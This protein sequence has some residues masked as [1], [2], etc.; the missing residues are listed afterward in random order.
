MFSFIYITKS[1]MSTLNFFIA[2][3]S[4]QFCT[5]TKDILIS[6]SPHFSKL[7]TSTNPSN[8]FVHLSYPISYCLLDTCKNKYIWTTTYPIIILN[9]YMERFS[10]MNIYYRIIKPIWA[11]WMSYHEKNYTFHLLLTSLGDRAIK[12]KYFVTFSHWL[13]YN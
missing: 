10:S 8:L 7:S 2:L 5:S 11:Y 12:I 6:A 13:H 3:F 9:G 1:G 4:L